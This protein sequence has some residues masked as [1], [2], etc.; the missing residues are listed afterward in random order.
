M[1]ALTSTGKVLRRLWEQRQ[2]PLIEE[3]TSSLVTIYFNQ[4]YS[5][6]LLILISSFTLLYDLEL[7]YSIYSSMIGQNDSYNGYFLPQSKT[8]GLHYWRSANNICGSRLRRIK[9]WRLR[10]HTVCQS[11]TV[12][13]CYYIKCYFLHS[14]YKICVSTRFVCITKIIIWYPST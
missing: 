6:I 14:V 9:T 12:L 3:E 10:D 8:I 1:S 11:I 5:I 4:A 7:N 2:R 13:I